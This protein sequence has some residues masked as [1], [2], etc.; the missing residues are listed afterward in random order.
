MLPRGRL[1]KQKQKAKEKER[2]ER[3]R[4]EK[5]AADKEAI[6]PGGYLDVEDDDDEGGGGGSYLDV[7]E[8]DDGGPPISPFAPGAGTAKGLLAA[9]IVAEGL[10]MVTDIVKQ[11]VDA[12]LAQP[13]LRR[14]DGT[15][16]SPAELRMALTEAKVL[17]KVL[18][19]PKV[20]KPAGWKGE[21]WLTAA[22]RWWRVPTAAVS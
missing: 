20:P 13:D 18:K 21:S 11:F 16:K 1:K 19:Q 8:P 4:A 5:Q 2:K 6:E 17:T 9:D 3:E 7:D 12:G 22:L 15:I 14:A 10:E